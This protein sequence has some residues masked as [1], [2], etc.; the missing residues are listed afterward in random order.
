[1]WVLTGL[2]REDI[3][4]SRFILCLSV[5]KELLIV[6]LQILKKEKGTH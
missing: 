1:M 5:W 2:V 4:K 3:I 6:V